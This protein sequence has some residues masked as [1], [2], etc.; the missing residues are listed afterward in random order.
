MTISHVFSHLILKVNE[1]GRCYY[2]L[3]FSHEET[4]RSNRSPRG[5]HSLNS[6]S[7]FFTVPTTVQSALFPFYKQNVQK[8]LLT[9][10]TIQSSINMALDLEIRNIFSSQGNWEHPS[11]TFDYHKRNSPFLHYCLVFHFYPHGSTE[12]SMYPRYRWIFRKFCSPLKGV[13]F[14]H[15]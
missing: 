12:H 14:A 5:C 13:K 9:N 2:Y 3:H 15:I 10:P 1:H 6:K 7:L 4:Q 11:I 8:W